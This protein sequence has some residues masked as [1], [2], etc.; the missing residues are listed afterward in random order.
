[1]YKWNLNQRYIKQRLQYIPNLTFQKKVINSIS[2][3]MAGKP[4]ICGRNFFFSFC[5]NFK[6]RLMFYKPIPLTSRTSWLN[7]I[8]RI[9]SWKKVLDNV[10]GDISQNGSGKG[11]GLRFTKRS[12]GLS[13]YWLKK[14][15]DVVWLQ[16]RCVPQ[17]LLHFAEMI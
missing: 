5:W 6:R 14:S 13:N 10:L 12:S 3:L 9:A 4:P 16:F 8:Q 7:T 2:H 1:M 17:T 15:R 11:R